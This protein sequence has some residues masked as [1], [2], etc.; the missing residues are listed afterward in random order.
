MELLIR[1]PDKICSFKIWIELSN[2][3]LTYI[4]HFSTI[5]PIQK[6]ISRFMTIEISFYK[7]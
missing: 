7:L 2:M 6:F 3:N 5:E 1:N 4:K